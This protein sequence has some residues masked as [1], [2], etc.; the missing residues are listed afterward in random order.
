MGTAQ[1]VSPA[2][3][4]AGLWLMFCGVVGIVAGVVPLVVNVL[5]VFG[6][7]LGIAASHWAAH[8]PEAMGMGVDWATLSC[9]DGTFLGSLLLAAGI[10]WW[11]A[12]PWAPLV[13]L[14]YAID[15]LIVN[16]TDLMLFAVYAAHGP[17]RTLMLVLDGAAG[18]VA[19]TTMIGLIVWWCR[20]PSG[21]EAR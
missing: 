7:D 20:Q 5:R 17:T 13:T 19:A 3:R 10:G 18:S 4:R 15:G 6:T 8:G 1:G 9:A 16:G 14:I 21:R 2:A 11:R 12:R